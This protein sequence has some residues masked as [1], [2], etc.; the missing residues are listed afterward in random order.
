MNLE[1]RDAMLLSLH[2][3]DPLACLLNRQISH[4][5]LTQQDPLGK[6][7]KLYGMR[8]KVHTTVSWNRDYHTT[9]IYV[10]HLFEEL[11]RYTGRGTED[12]GF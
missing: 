7:V 5:C 4:L 11:L 6:V 1:K 3:T 2:S 12:A 10:S 9:L 8:N